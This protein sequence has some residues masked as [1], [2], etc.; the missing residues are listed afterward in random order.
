MSE[1]D[2]TRFP[3]G[4]AKGNIGGHLRKIAQHTR[5]K[6]DSTVDVKR[7]VDT[8]LQLC[9]EAANNGEEAVKI[10]VRDFYARCYRGSTGTHK[11]N[12]AE[13]RLLLKELRECGLHPSFDQCN[14]TTEYLCADWR[15]QRFASGDPRMGMAGVSR[16]CPHDTDTIP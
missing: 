11:L 2:T 6:Q 1:S 9:L 15:E 4:I 10:P 3:D 5:A 7:L 12:P 8:A 14:P 16:F 13:R